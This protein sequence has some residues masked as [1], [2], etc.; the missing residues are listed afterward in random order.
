M[1]LPKVLLLDGDGVIWIDTDPIKGAIESLNKIRALGVRLVLVTNNC[2]KTRGQ[3][4]KFMEK[5]GLYGFTE[6]DVFTSG[7]ATA[8]YLKQNN[9]NKVFVS[10]FD[11]LMDEFRL[12]NI[13]VHTLETDPEV[14]PVDAVVCSKSPRFSYDEL[15]R[16]MVLCRKYGA[17]LVG[18]NPDITFPMAGGVLI[19]GSGSIV[20]AFENAVGSKATVIGKPNDPMFDTMMSALGVSKDEVIMV[21]DRMLTDIPFAR[22]HGAR[23]IL[24]LSGIDKREDGENA[25]EEERP[26]YILP[27]LVE[28]AELLEN[29]KKNQ[30]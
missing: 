19:C 21:G 16:G 29:M 23:A 7:Y 13:D 14:M 24:V 10:G 9:L 20:G 27:S 25:P 6:D 3:Y 2:S 5:M 15:A 8:L 11:G 17:K 28:V 22:R 18:T 1:S 26:T 12:H 30:Q 4:L